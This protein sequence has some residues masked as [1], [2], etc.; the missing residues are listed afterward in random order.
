MNK[1]SVQIQKNR[2]FLDK[3]PRKNKI[4]YTQGINPTKDHGIVLLDQKYWDQI[5]DIVLKEDLIDFISYT[6]IFPEKINREGYRKLIEENPTY[7]LD[8]YV[9]SKD[10]ILTVYLKV[11]DTPINLTKLN[12]AKFKKT[13]VEKF[14]EKYASVK[15]ICRYKKIDKIPTYDFKLQ[16]FRINNPHEMYIC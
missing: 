6:Q 15:I 13:L 3:K 10:G 5:R 1:I 4:S 14:G 2:S 8:A 12:E 16:K 7:Y 11:L 9:L